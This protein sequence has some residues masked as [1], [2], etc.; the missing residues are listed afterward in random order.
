MNNDILLDNPGIRIETHSRTTAEF[1]FIIKQPTDLRRSRVGVHENL[2]LLYF[3]G[4][5][6]SVF[7]DG[8]DYS[9]SKGNIVVVNAYAIHQ[10]VFEGEVPVFCLIIDRKFCQY[11]GVDPMGLLFRPLIRDDAQLT[12]LFRQMMDAYEA[13]EEQ[14]GN[15]AFKCAVLELL[16]HLCRRYSSPRLEDVS[17]SPALDRMRRAIGY[18]KSNFARKITCDDIAASAGLSQYHFQ[19]EFKRITGKTPNHYLNAIRCVHARRLLEGGR[20]SVKEAAFLSG[21]TNL[22][23]FSNVFRRYIGVLPSQIRPER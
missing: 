12:A 23:H 17:K 18:M 10:V 7:Y 15:P 14:F 13:R 8:A 20:H 3:Q 4:G 9:V 21:F 16:L 5:E 2:E 1:P 19:R 11:C 22:S 6:G